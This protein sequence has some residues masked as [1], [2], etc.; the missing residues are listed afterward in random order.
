MRLMMKHINFK[1]AFS[2]G[3]FTLGHIEQGYHQCRSH[4]FSHNPPKL[5]ILRVTVQSLTLLRLVDCFV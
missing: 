1:D 2:S 5:A 3:V 4:E